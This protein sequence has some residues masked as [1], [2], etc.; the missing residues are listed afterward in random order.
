MRRL[1][2]IETELARLAERNPRSHWRIRRDRDSDGADE[3]CG[4]ATVAYRGGLRRDHAHFG[5][6]LAAPALGGGDGMASADD[7]VEDPGAGDGLDAFRGRRGVRHCGFRGFV[8][9]SVATGVNAETTPRRA[10]RELR[11]LIEERSRKFSELFAKALVQ[12]DIEVI[13]DLRVCSRRLQQCLD[14]VY[15][16][17]PP[18]KVRRAQRMLRRV[19]HAVGEWRNC[20]V[21]LGLLDRRRPDGHKRDARARESVRARRARQIDKARRRLR[22][23]DLDR[24]AAAAR[25]AASR[26]GRGADVR[27]SIRLSIDRAW[28]EWEAALS[29][30][31]ADASIRNLHAL[32]IATKRLRYRVELAGDVGERRAAE[33][34]PWLE[35]LQDAIG[36]WHDRQLLRE[37]AG[38]PAKGDRLWDRGGLREIFALSRRTKERDA[39]TGWIAKE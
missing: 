39:L 1:E 17:T 9:D 13:H 11:R 15:P 14:G 5:S 30:A 38:H 12:E 26:C 3:P 18:P 20:D 8:A 6:L 24:L 2:S 19:R 7:H 34:L 28:R 32:R 35:K 33:V 22:R 4:V 16:Q 10:G 29:M 27:A 25:K 31:R 21:V 36:R 37:V 23:E